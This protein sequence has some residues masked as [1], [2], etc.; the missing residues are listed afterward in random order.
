MNAEVAAMS[1]MV[2]SQ[3]THLAEMGS[4]VGYGEQKEDLAD[5]P[6]E[7]LVLDLLAMDNPTAA[8]V[9]LVVQK[10]LKAPDSESNIVAVMKSAWKKN[11]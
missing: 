8:S 4:M 1:A 7:A 6:L 10:H 11:L 9:D 5:D 2:F 3:F